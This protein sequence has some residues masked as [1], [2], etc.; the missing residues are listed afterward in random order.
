MTGSP[1]PGSVDVPEIARRRTLSSNHA[2]ASMS[3]FRPISELIQRVGPYTLVER[4]GAGRVGVVYAALN[5][6]MNERVAIKV[7]R[8]GVRLRAT[9]EEL[10]GLTHPNIMAVRELGVTEHDEQ[11]IAM[12]LFDGGTLRGW[13]AE[14]G[15]GRAEL[16]R[17]FTAI[18]RG[19]IAAHDAGV[20]HGCF[21]PENVLLDDDGRPIITDFGLPEANPTPLQQPGGLPSATSTKAGGRTQGA[22]DGALPY[23]SPEQFAGLPGDD[24]SDQYSFCVAL[25]EAFYGYRPFAGDTYVELRA[26]VTAGRRARSH[27]SGQSHVSSWIAVAIERGL[28]TDPNARFPSMGAL[29]EAIERGPARRSTGAALAIVAASILLLALAIGYALTRAG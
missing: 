29:I 10:K 7:L 16:L 1:P 4:L 17:V 8:R 5:S 20:I 23:L 2:S 18:G 25:H 14:G 24:R 13:I 12:E 27:D 9:E 15:H 19:L 6:E 22:G 26:S 11:Y 21:S 28:S 3:A